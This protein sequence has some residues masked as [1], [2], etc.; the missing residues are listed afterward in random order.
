MCY[1]WHI[2]VERL[3]YKNYW[4]LY[5]LTFMHK[6]IFLLYGSWSS[7]GGS[8]TS[9]NTYSLTKQREEEINWISLSPIIHMQCTWQLGQS[10]YLNSRIHKQ[11]NKHNSQIT[12]QVCMCI[13]SPYLNLRIHKQITKQ[14]SKIPIWVCLWIYIACGQSY[15]LNSRFTN[16]SKNPKNPK[17]KT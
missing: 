3:S 14:N 9:T 1:Y 15:Y 4:W 7:C 12:D 11:I 17:K 16:K 6:S 2:E 8:T 10:Q 5:I 13:Q